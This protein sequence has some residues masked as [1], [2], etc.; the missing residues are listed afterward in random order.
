[1]AEKKKPMITLFRGAVT[2][3]ALPS[4]IAVCLLIFLL[5]ASHG[6][7]QQLDINVPSVIEVEAST[8]TPLPIRVEP[9]DAVPKRAMVLIR[10]LPSSIA[11]S[12]GRLFNSGVWAIRVTDLPHLKLASPAIVGIRSSL[13]LSAVALDGA[14]LAKAT[15][16]LV[17]TA[18]QPRVARAAPE[19]VAKTATTRPTVA[20]MTPEPAEETS[21]AVTPRE[22]PVR[23]PLTPEDM[24]RV[25]MFMAKAGENLTNGNVYVARLFY[26]RAANL[27]W[28]PAALALGS[29]YDAAELEAVGTV[30]GIQPD[31]KLAAHWYKKA[32]DLG[33]PEAESRL[34]RLSAR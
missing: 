20:I 12:E 27:G 25:E 17:V 24:Q 30:G 1:M 31:A 18:P 2:V 7:A 19:A 3:R 8:E 11:L 32:R 9:E 16:S 14:V 23:K 29:T 26:K 10:G 6:T 4:R 13:D 5:P 22:E 28:P 15:S 21:T 34:S 33:A